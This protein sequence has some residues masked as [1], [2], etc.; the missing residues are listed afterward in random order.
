[1]DDKIK[2]EKTE[3]AKKFKAF[4]SELKSSVSCDDGQWTIKG[5]IDIYKNVFTISSDTK[6][7]SKILEIHLFPTISRFAESIGYN[8]VLAEKQNYYPD[9]TFIKK[10]DETIKFAVDL[11]TTFRRSNGKIGFTLG[12]HGA[13]FANR[14]GKKNIQFPYQEYKGHFCLGVIYSK[15]NDDEDSNADLNETKILQVAELGTPKTKDN[16]TRDINQKEK[17]QSITSVI[18]DLDFFFSEKWKIASDSQGS[19]NTANIGSIDNEKDIKEENGVFAK[20]GEDYF[21][22]YWTNYDKA[23]IKVGEKL[24]KITN[25]WDFLES[26]GEKDKW[27]LVGNGAKKRKVQ[28]KKK[29]VDDKKNNSSSNKKPRNKNK[30]GSVHK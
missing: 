26:R 18:K 23:T 19:G 20:L 3:F 8:I 21:D 22:L 16:V 15:A 13:Y 12:S 11:K 29:K 9:L 2:L 1:M 14:E 17:L 6:I 25:I 24:K 30:T 10:D 4:V 7:I 5:F 27:K 28:D